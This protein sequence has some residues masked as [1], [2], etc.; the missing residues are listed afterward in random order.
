VRLI[1]APEGAKPGTRV[2]CP[3]AATTIKEPLSSSQVK[4]KKTFENVAAKLVLGP[5]GEVQFNGVALTV[6]SPELLQHVKCDGEGWVE[7]AK[8]S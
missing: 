2:V 8:V 4:K 7:G 1:L 3:S 6:P 5:S